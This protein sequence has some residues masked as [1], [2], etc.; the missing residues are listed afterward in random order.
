MKTK[1]SHRIYISVSIVSLAKHRKMGKK[2]I[3]FNHFLTIFLETTN[4]LIENLTLDQHAVLIE[5]YMNVC[6]CV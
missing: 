2:Y 6:V 1:F 5:H 3:F 4:S